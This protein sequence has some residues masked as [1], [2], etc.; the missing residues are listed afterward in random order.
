MEP[1]P[2]QRQSGAAKFDQLVVQALQPVE[3]AELR[4]IEDDPAPVELGLEVR[5]QRTVAP[6]CNVGFG[7]RFVP[8]WATQIMNAAPPA[9]SN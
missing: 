9:L 8:E 6:R 5:E 1:P 2:K 4:M 7:D 3:G